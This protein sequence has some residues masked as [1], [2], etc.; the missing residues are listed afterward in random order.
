MEFLT[1]K[2]LP[3]QAA[4]VTGNVETGQYV[5]GLLPAAVRQRKVDLRWSRGDLGETLAFAHKAYHPHGQHWIEAPVLE[6]TAQVDTRAGVYVNQGGPGDRQMVAFWAEDGYVLE[7]RAEVPD[8][9]A[10]KERLGWLTRVDSQTWLDAMPASVVKAADHDA[11]VRE[12]LRGIPVPDTFTPSRIP[13]EGLTT[14]RG[15][16]AGAVTGTVACLWFRQW[17]Q[18]RR[19]GDTAKKVEAE[20]AMATSKQWPILREI[21][22]GGPYPLMIWQLA[23]AMPSGEWR[24]GWRLLPHA[25]ALGCARLGIPV[26][27]WKQRRQNERGGP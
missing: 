12:M 8:L 19:T 16:V 23:E 4:R 25:E 10:M 6:T 22:E 26:L 24:R 5:T 21:S 13:D 18:A 20:R 27:P 11:T 3:Y 17:G 1:G 9:A 15:Q 7:L 2:P 14:D